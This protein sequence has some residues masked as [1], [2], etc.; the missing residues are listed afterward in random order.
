MQPAPKNNYPVRLIQ[1]D[2]SIPNSV[3]Q[4]GS[5]LPIIRLLPLST[6]TQTTPRSF[7]LCPSAPQRFARPVGF[8]QPPNYPF[9][10]LISRAEFLLPAP[11]N[12]C[13]QSHPAPKPRGHAPA[14]LDRPTRAATALRQLD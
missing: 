14:L 9:Q 2:S 4:F 7:R 5:V 12:G 1:L 8:P 13:A 10:W 3:D 6:I 11:P